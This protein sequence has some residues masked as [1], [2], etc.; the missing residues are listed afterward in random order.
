M[1]F[2]G[3][4]FQESFQVIFVSLFLPFYALFPVCDFC[5]LR[6]VKE[7]RRK[8][9]RKN[10][11]KKEILGSSRDGHFHIKKPIHESIEVENTASIFS[12]GRNSKGKKEVK[13]RDRQKGSIPTAFKGHPS[14]PSDSIG[15]DPIVKM[16]D[17]S[18]PFPFSILKLIEVETLTLT[19]AIRWRGISGNGEGQMNHRVEERKRERERDIFPS[20]SLGF[21]FKK[22]RLIIINSSHNFF[23]SWIAISSDKY[24]CY[25]S[26]HFIHSSFFSFPSLSTSI[27]V[28]PFLRWESPIP[29]IFVS[30][31]MN[32]THI[33]HFFPSL[34]ITLPETEFPLPSSTLLPVSTIQSF[35]TITIILKR[36]ATKITS[37]ISPLFLSN[38]FFFLCRESDSEQMRERKE[39]KKYKTHII[40][41]F[42]GHRVIIPTPSPNGS[43][44]LSHL[45][46]IPQFSNNIS[47]RG[48]KTLETRQKREEL[49]WGHLLILFLW[50]ESNVTETRWKGLDERND[51]SNGSTLQSSVNNLKW[52]TKGDVVFLFQFLVY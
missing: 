23:S 26:S 4:T 18:E 6:L 33:R 45:G 22:E 2:S 11:K 13:V 41:H 3:G 36:A 48:E 14:P 27:F 46:G 8:W 15:F 32:Q 52:V 44:T 51:D 1:Q 9:T 28:S 21:S 42:D 37:K 49:S 31:E 40:H 29:S 10:R 7:E 24:H 50:M 39:G 17:F 30:N 43:V 38:P 35:V 34:S 20:S 47:G 25:I 5:S 12:F 16:A 19:R